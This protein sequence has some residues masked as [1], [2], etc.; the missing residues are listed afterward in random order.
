LN[1]ILDDLFIKDE[2]DLDILPN[3]LVIPKRC[4]ICRTSQICALISTFINISKLNILISVEQCP[5]YKPL[6]I[7]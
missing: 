6:K 7:K 3:E 2:S 1:S 5:H 4:S